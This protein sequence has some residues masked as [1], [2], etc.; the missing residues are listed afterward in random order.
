MHLGQVANLR[1][2]LAQALIESSR[3]RGDGPTRLHSETTPFQ[4]IGLNLGD[5]IDRA[6]KVVF[7]SAV[8]A[9]L[10]IEGHDLQHGDG[11]D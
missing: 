6:L 11:G 4:Q 1:V 3:R 9:V 7:L 5:G 8:N 10:D 2:T